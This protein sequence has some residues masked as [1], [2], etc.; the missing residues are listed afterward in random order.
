MYFMLFSKLS[1]EFSNLVIGKSTCFEFKEPQMSRVTMLRVVFISTIVLGYLVVPHNTNAKLYAASTPVSAIHKY[2]DEMTSL[3]RGRVDQSVV[4]SLATLWYDAM[5][6]NAAKQLSLALQINANAASRDNAAM[7]T[8]DSAFTEAIY[9]LAD[10]NYNATT[11]ALND[12]D[13]A[14]SKI[15]C[16]DLAQVYRHYTNLIRAL[17][18]I[19]ILPNNVGWS[20]AAKTLSRDSAGPA[21]PESLHLSAAIAIKQGAT[22]TASQQLDQAE[23]LGQQRATMIRSL[24]KSGLQLDIDPTAE[25]AEMCKSLR[26]AARAC[27]S[28][29]Q[30]SK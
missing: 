1:A 25:I 26:T 12:A 23:I 10:G 9:T 21:S 28:T 15:K 29:G 18:C 22:T 7:A 24:V 27:V 6:A 20:N 11:K 5:K 17:N 19:A 3:L 14:I 4:I 30:S 16:A 13:A 2:D 8:F